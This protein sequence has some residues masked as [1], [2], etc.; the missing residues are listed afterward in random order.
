MISDESP[1]PEPA[2]GKLYCEVEDDDRAVVEVY[3]VTLAEYNV[4]EEEGRHWLTLH[5]QARQ[6]IEPIDG[7]HPE[8][9][10]EVN[11][12]F[13]ADPR[14][15]LTAGRVLAVKAYDEELHNLTGLY[16]LTHD[17]FD[18]EVLVE[19]VVSGH[20]TARLTGESDSAMP[21][22]RSKGTTA[23]SGDGG[24]ARAP[25]RRNNS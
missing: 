10:L 17:Y 6:E 19:E 25:R 21:V 5:V 14:P 18:G 16:Y 12:P 24:N 23:R 22:R 1:V 8:P 2:L 4:Y 11:L 20:L 9:W 3:D 13:D 15:S 7:G